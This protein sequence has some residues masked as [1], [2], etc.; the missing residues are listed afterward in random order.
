MSDS[1]ETEIAR[2]RYVS[3][4]DGYYCNECGH[5]WFEDSAKQTVK[6]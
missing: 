1:L 5:E 6:A 4:S 2:N 3:V